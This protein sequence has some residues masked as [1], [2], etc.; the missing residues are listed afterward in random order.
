MFT[1]TEPMTAP[2][3]T[4]RP[5]ANTK[6]ILA[7]DLRIVGEI[8]SSGQIEVL[9]EVEGNLVAKGLL[10]GTEGRVSGTVNSDIV[11]VKGVLSGSVKSQSF[12]LRSTAEVQADVTYS[13]LTI[14]SGAQIEGKFALN[15]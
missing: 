9:G 12:A 1:K 7:S 3:T 15:K 14:E 10:I 6:S 13:T 11:E 5:G 8:S 2:T 4:A